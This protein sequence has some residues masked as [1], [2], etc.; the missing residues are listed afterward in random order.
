MYKNKDEMLKTDRMPIAGGAP[1]APSASPTN[2]TNHIHTHKHC[3]ETA[4]W[5][6]ART[7]PSSAGGS[8][9]S[10]R[11]RLLHGDFTMIS[12]TIIHFQKH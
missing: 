9:P 4:P 6:W 8:L 1:R 5:S 12:P 3:G 7:P 2:P 10:P 11:S